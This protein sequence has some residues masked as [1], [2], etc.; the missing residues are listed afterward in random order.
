MHPEKVAKFNDGQI[1]EMGKL[2]ELFKVLGDETR[3]KILY[4]LSKEEMCVCD[5]ASVL[6]A[7]VS[8][9]SHHLR[10]LRGAALV[11]YRKEGKVVYYTLDDHHVIN[12]IKEGLE[13]LAHRG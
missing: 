9:V 8:N 13:H 3:T 10:L 2:A 1:P 5:L 12:L 7:T 6:N 4:I 11:R